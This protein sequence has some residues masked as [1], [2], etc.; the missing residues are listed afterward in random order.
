M[1]YNNEFIAPVLTRKTMD[2][3]FHRVAIY[4]VVEEITPYLNG[5]LLDAGCGQMPYRSFILNNSNVTDYVGLDIETAINYSDEVKPDVTWNGKVMPF[6]DNSFECVMATEVLEHVPDT[7]NYLNE[8]YRVLK[9]GGTFFFTTPFLWPLHEV[10][11]DEYRFTPFAM[12][13]LLLKANFNNVEIQPLGGWHASLAQMLGLWL[14]RGPI[15]SKK[16]KILTILFFPFYKYL[17][18]KDRKVIYN[19]DMITGLWGSVRK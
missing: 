1:I 18:K 17:I 8:V 16:R 10:P 15:P 14:K 9:P 5:T 19:S 11:H 2:R 12:K 7:I 6:D 4:Q 13:R 3:Y